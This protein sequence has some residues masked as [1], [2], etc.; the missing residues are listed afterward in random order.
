[1]ISEQKKT[2]FR[3]PLYFVD[4]FFSLFRQE[5]KWRASFSPGKIAKDKFKVLAI[6]W[7]MLSEVEVFYLNTKTIF[8]AWKKCAVRRAGAYRYKN[9]WII[10]NW[11]K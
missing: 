3:G 4:S 9:P 11:V 5:K 1:L 8:F 2:V 10:A 6:G 7:I